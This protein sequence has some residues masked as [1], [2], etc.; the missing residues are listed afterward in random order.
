MKPALDFILVR[1]SGLKSRITMAMLLWSLAVGLPGCMA[2]TGNP[3][4]TAAVSPTFDGPQVL[5]D[6][7]PL[8]LSAAP[9]PFPV[10]IQRYFD[11]YGLGFGAERHFFGYFTSHKFRISAQVWLP[12]D[13][14]GTMFLLH[15]YL[16]HAAT[17]RHLIGA[18]IAR[19]YAVAV[20][21]LP[22]HGLS[23]GERG[24]IDVFDDY[25]R[26]FG[27]FMALCAPHLPHPFHLVGHS[28]GCAI[29]LAY[30]HRTPAA[31]FDRAVFLSP[32]VHH[33]HWRLAKFGIFMAQW[34]VDAIDRSYRRNS[35]DAHFVA[36]VRQDPLQGKRVTIKFLKALY[37]WEQRARQ[38]APMPQSLLMIQG[39]EDEIVDWQYNL[40]FLK[41]KLTGASVKLV[42]TARHQLANESSE[43]RKEVLMRTF[44]FLSSGGR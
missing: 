35:S 15:G 39:A 37:A 5:K 36:F 1:K 28:T 32:L 25:V 14:R 7:L 6:M 17:L 41:T 12:R 38:Y 42:E 27:D 3:S 23:S 13:P 30:L 22:G 11:Y 33:A 18:A 34:F 10:S 31:G 20:F 21:D 40:P 19:R 29:A 4:G 44:E 2:Q 43:I 16:D 9:R 26:V 24:A 8:D